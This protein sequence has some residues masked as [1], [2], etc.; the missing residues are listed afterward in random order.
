MPARLQKT[1]GETGKQDRARN[2]DQSSVRPNRDEKASPTEGGKGRDVGMVALFG[3][4]RRRDRWQALR[5][6]MDW[7]RGR[8]GN[9]HFL[10]AKIV[11][12]GLAQS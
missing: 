12:T 6:P 8:D 7:K 9:Q 4:G 1:S 5:K 2:Q 3:L 10:E 11:K